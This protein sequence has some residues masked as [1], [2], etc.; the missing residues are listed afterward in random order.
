MTRQLLYIACALSTLLGAVPSSV[1]QAQS[2]PDQVRCEAYFATSW[3]A[4][5]RRSRSARRSSRAATQPPDVRSYLKSVYLEFESASEQELLPIVDQWAQDYLAEAEPS[6]RY[7]PGLRPHMPETRVG[8][9][10]LDNLNHV[11]GNTL[12]G[13]TLA[14]DELRVD[15][16]NTFGSLDSAHR[17]HGERQ[18]RTAR[19]VLALH[20]YVGIVLSPPGR[21]FEFLRAWNQTDEMLRG[22]LGLPQGN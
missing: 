21:D 10:D 11:Y 22:R 7:L 18:R 13:L 20:R 1:A 12:A 14:L 15:P 2:G 19:A 16:S 8:Q 9:L 17:E 6:R 5:V 4:P 3:E